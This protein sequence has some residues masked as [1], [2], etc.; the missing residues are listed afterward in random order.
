M[1]HRLTSGLAVVF[2][3]LSGGCAEKFFFYPDQ[4][5][6]TTPQAEGVHAEEV[7]LAGPD[8]T[9]LHGWWL[10]AK[11]PA[12][13]TVLHVHGNAANISNHLP[14]VAWLPAAGFNVLTFDYRGYGRSG[15][16]PSIH[17]VVD[18]TRAA[19][20]WLRRRDGVDAQ[21]LAVIG[22]SLGGATA[23]RAVV[24]EPQG[25]RLLVLDSAFSSY[26]GI[27][28]EAAGSMGALGWLAPVLI[29]T[30]PAEEHDP[31]RAAAKLAVPLLVLHGSHDAVIPQ[32]HGHALW[33]AAN[34]PKH[35]LPIEGG[36][37]IDALMRPDVRAQVRDAMLA[38]LR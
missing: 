10:P 29:P 35:W 9:A 3:A 18:D 31:V 25:V 20:A 30:L 7:S 26:R 15:G 5:V 27:A 1:S 2:A 34:A 6:Y 13:G 23:L 33:A 14:L 21:R 28:R 17:G 37:H 22:Q 11:G 38:A 12:H 24:Q 4:R 19:L 16:K 8:D 32:H 36:E